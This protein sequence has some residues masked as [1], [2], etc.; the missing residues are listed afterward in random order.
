MKKVEKKL[1]RA[2][3]S[4]LRFCQSRYIS[5]TESTETIYA[6]PVTQPEPVVKKGSRLPR[7]SCAEFGLLACEGQVLS[8]YSST[9]ATVAEPEVQPQNLI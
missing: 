5:T 6:P 2:L 9:R 4:M 7:P 3:D 1:P 8:W